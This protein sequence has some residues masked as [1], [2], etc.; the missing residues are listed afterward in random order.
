MEIKEIVNLQRVFVQHPEDVIYA[1]IR[2]SDE[3]L[4]RLNLP[5]AP[6]DDLP[7]KIEERYE[8]DIIKLYTFHKNFLPEDYIRTGY[9]QKWPEVYNHRDN[10]P[11]LLIQNPLNE[12]IYGKISSVFKLR[13]V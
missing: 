12:Q 2:C 9:P 1:P 10:M 5:A 4:D 11:D 3:I 8:K 6:F 13:F 7:T